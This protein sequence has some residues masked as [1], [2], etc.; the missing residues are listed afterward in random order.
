MLLTIQK[1]YELLA[2][3]GCFARE[4]VA[5]VLRTEDATRAGWDNGAPRLITPDDHWRCRE[6]GGMR[7]KRRSDGQC[8]YDDQ[9]QDWYFFELSEWIHYCFFL[10]LLRLGL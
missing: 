7:C 9:R 4:L 10:S 8:D 3:Y 6:V 1:S 5:V 2:N